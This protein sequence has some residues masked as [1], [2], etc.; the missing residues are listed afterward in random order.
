MC[1]AFFHAV[2][3]MTVEDYE[4]QFTGLFKRRFVLENYIKSSKYIKDNG[5]NYVLKDQ[6]RLI[7]LCEVSLQIPE[8]KSAFQN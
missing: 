8:V 5:L 4:K 7:Q 2:Q 3:N 1:I 6:D